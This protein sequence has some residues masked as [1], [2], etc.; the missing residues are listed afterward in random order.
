[1]ADDASTEELRHRQAEKERA[2][3]EGA[4]DAVTDAEA[5]VHMRRAKKAGY[6]RRKLAERE[7]A[8]DLTDDE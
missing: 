5:E 8:E 1:M 6:L 4:D 3:R 7:R 2:E